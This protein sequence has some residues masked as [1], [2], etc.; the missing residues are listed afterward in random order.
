ML[1]ATHTG[2]F[3]RIAS[4]GAQKGRSIRIHSYV[5]TGLAKEI[6]AYNAAQEKSL[7]EKG[8][9][10]ATVAKD[11]AGNYLFTQIA[12]W[13]TGNLAQPELDLKI[14]FNGYATV[15]M[16][17]SRMAEERELRDEMKSNMARIAAEVAMGVT[18]VSVNDTSVSNVTPTAAASD[19]F[20]DIVQKLQD[21]PILEEVGTE[22]LGG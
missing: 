10:L 19:E 11:P 12:N 13:Q 7:T 5:V 20:H 9:D 21:T 15:D 14:T 2:S 1:K 17:I 22:T 8:Y 6:A 16:E 18:K 4:K 3:T